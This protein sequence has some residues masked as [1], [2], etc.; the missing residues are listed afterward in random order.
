MDDPVKS[1]EALLQE[2][3]RLRDKIA[4]LEAR[5]PE[6]QS[7]KELKSA[8]ERF[9]HLLSSSPAIIYTTLASGTYACTYVS[10]NIRSIMGFSPDEMTTDAKCWP[11]QLHPDD[12]ERVLSELGPL[13]EHGGGTVEYRFRH[14]NGHY[15]WIQ[16]SFK[17]VYDDTGAAT[18]EWPSNATRP[19]EL[20]GAWADITE[21]KEAEQAAL[22]AN[23]QL[24]ETK[25]SLSRLIESSPDAIISTDKAG[26]IVLFNEGAETL[27]GYRSDEVVGK[28]VSRI[29]GGE[30]GANEVLREMRKRG[31]TVSGFDSVLWA[32][33][34]TSIPVLISAS[35]LFGD[36]GE[37]IGTVGFATDLRERKRSQEELQNAYDELEK[38]VEARTTELNEARGRLQ[39]LLTVTPGIMYT[40][41]VTDGYRCSFVSRNIDPIMGFSE[42]EMLE[43]SEFWLKRV[44]PEDTE[45]VFQEM[46]PLVEQGGGSIEYRFRHRDGNYVWIQDTFKV[47]E[48]D[49][50]KPLEIVG[51]WADITHR[52]QVEQALGERMALMNDLQNLVAA[53]P[54]VIYTTKASGNF[55][56]TFVSE[57]LKTTMGYAPWEMREDPK[58]WLKRLHPEDAG[59]VFN[60]LAKL[61]A[62]GG[63]VIEYRFRHRR[64]HYIWIQD[65]FT[66]TKDKDG[67]PMELIGSWA[68]ISDRKKIE[69]ELKRLAGEV[70]VRNRFIRDTFGRYLTDEVVTTLL[71]SPS[72][73]QM[74]GEKRKIT[75]LMADLRGFTSLS[76]S[77]DPKWVVNMLNRYLSSMVT[78]IKKYGGTIDEFIGDAVFVIFGAPTWHDD[79][80]QRAAACAVEMQLAMKTVNE[81][82]RTDGLPDIE[83]GIG[84][85]TGQVI[86]GNIGSAERLKYG[87][88]GSHVNLTSRIQ[89]LT[90]GGQILASESTRREVGTMLKIAKQMEVR[91]KG[92]EQP[93]TICEV[94][95][96]GGP[97]KLMLYQSSEPLVELAQALEFTYQVLESDLQ[98]DDVFSGRFTKLA[99]KRAEAYLA[100]PVS[101]LCN[102]KIRIRSGD[103]GFVAGTLYAKVVATGS[104]NDVMV[105][106]TSMPREVEVVLRACRGEPEECE[107]APLPPASESNG[108]PGIQLGAA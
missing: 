2:V 45:R 64:G 42:W 14:R 100:K 66:A 54:A 28:S 77:L 36:D 69:A 85:H 104:R 5:G 89:S 13:I 101:A 23:A 93:I 24:Q 74:G 32:K 30:A 76:E 82:N 63:G 15:V 56:C 80:A 72:G 81:R 48:D 67:N 91:A 52:K 62:Q 19:L 92:F 73:M 43:D 68:D 78:I 84:L 79:D 108:E 35:M 90:V 88:V 1:S 27:L 60:E 33:D 95:G 9:E 6:R 7:E 46:G 107:C 20:I 25:R 50:G 8:Q 96:I 87:V 21:R 57:N 97:H 65:T 59:H 53:S 40:N 22:R 106:F 103:K 10:E 44:H 49:S 83:M 86:V 16:D 18:G 26:C 102:L 37:Q 38:R 3:A 34:G 98:D 47:V 4:E 12:A 58:F 39:Y 99:S 105:H 31:G 71:D 11:D 17:V 51:S 94:V 75:M 41:Q 61:I 70:E 29:Y 55:S